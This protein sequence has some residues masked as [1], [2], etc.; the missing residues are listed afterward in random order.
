[1]A[2]TL[3]FE[4]E[5]KLLNFIKI[6][7]EGFTTNKLVTIPGR[8]HL[9]I[10]FVGKIV[11]DGINYSKFGDKEIW[12]FAFKFNEPED[13]STLKYLIEPFDIPQLQEW[14]RAP[15]SKN[16][17]IFFKVKRGEFGGFD[18]KTNYD[19]DIE[20]IEKDTEVIVTALASA[21]FDVREKTYGIYFNVKAVTV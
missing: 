17:T 12:S 11:G 7:K 21:Y 6:K 20:G 2:L 3:S 16:E 5:K 13:L 14:S 10:A 18:F 9:E 1:M 8:K 15:I 19:G 4:D